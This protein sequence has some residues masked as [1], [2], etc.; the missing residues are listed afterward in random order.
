[1]KTVING[2]EITDKIA[3]VLKDWYKESCLLSVIFIKDDL[4]KF[5]PSREEFEGG[6]KQ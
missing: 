3:E 4:E 2:V 1:M 5:I 6:N